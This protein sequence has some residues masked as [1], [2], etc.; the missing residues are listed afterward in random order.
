MIN[1]LLAALLILSAAGCER[2]PTDESVNQHFA[3][4]NGPVEFTFPAGWY[5]NQKEH[6]FDLQC[7]SRHERMNT[8]VFLFTKED[9]AQDVVP[10]ELLEQQI[11]DLGSKRTNF[12]VFEKEQVVQLEGKRLTTVVY[13]GE[14]G[15]SRNY[16]RFTLVEFAGNP[17]L[18]PVVLQMSIP[19]YWRENKPVLEAIT[20]S[21]RVRSADSRERR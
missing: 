6:P 11:Q 16:Y 13:S 2:A 7:F 5:K 10:K 19:S 4:V 1:W 15:L 3:V 20:A 14:N 12:K 8:G 17:A 9:L 18:I 21:A